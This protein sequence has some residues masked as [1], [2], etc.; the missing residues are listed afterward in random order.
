MPASEPNAKSCLKAI[1]LLAEAFFGF[2]AFNRSYLK[3]FGLT[4][5]QFDIIATLANTNG[6]T[7]RELGERTLITKGTLTGVVDRLSAMGLVR[8]VAGQPDRRTLKVVLTVKGKDMFEVAY[9]AIVGEL[10]KLM[11]AHGYVNRDFAAL[12]RDL[13]RLRDVFQDGQSTARAA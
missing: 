1:R 9:P 10:R 13:V 7:F 12:S 2:E 3:Q 8:R 11:Q 4:S 6:M 5:A